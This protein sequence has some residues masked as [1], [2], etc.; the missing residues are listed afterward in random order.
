MSTTEF[1]FVS[2]FSAI[3][4]IHGTNK[5]SVEIL[6]YGAT[7]VSWNV[8]DQKILFLSD[9]ASFE[10]GKGIRG[11]IPVV[12]PQF[13]PG[14][15]PQHGFARTKKW[16][17]GDT[18]VDKQTGDVTA[19]FHLHDDEDTL[20][21]WPFTFELTL[22]IT[23][24]A[25]KFEQKL[26]VINKDDKQ[27]DFTALLHTYF[28]VSDI[29]KTKIS[30]LRNI[31]Y[32]DKVDNATLK[33]ETNEYIEFV[34]ETD[35]VYKNGAT[36]NNLVT[37]IDNSNQQQ[38]EIQIK[39]Q[40]F[41]DFVIWNPWIEKAKNSNDIGEHNYSKFVCVEAGQVSKPVELNSK[42]TWNASQEISLIS[43]S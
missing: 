27:F 23:L 13:G 12:F 29:N 3:R 16:T 28:T 32:I 5:A 26:T 8:N 6:L 34:S 33:H 36:N 38:F 25:N 7:V 37:I 43:H 39:T 35:R 11:G 9:K 4:L 21:I 19:K 22:S 31:D 14:K 1:E 40:T 24:K 2:G 30:G 41:N 17:L 20:K 15:L 10:N 18:N 42:Q